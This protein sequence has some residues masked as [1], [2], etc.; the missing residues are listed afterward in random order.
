MDAVSREEGSQRE[1]DSS[2]PAPMACRCGFRLL[3]QRFRRYAQH[4]QEDAFVLGRQGRSVEADI[5]LPGLGNAAWSRGLRDR[6]LVHDRGVVVGFRDSGARYGQE[7]DCAEVGHDFRTL[8]V[9]LG[10][11][12]GGLFG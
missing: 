1:D 12:E 3:L 4:H 9:V 5:L 11:E 2:P 8:R 6:V 10:G 7:C